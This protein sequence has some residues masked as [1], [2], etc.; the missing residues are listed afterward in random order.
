MVCHALS[1][2]SRGGRQVQTSLR[3]LRQKFLSTISQ[4]ESKSAGLSHTQLR[5]QLLDGGASLL[6]SDTL[7]QELGALGTKFVFG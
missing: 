6:A 3:I 4:A 7:Q 2:Q 5:R 1:R